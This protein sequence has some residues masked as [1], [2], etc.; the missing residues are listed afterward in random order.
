MMITEHL[1]EISENL[2]LLSSK[3]SNMLISYVTA[4][5]FENSVSDFFEI[6]NLTNLI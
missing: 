5:P 2:D 3:N 4:E 6:Y 1:R